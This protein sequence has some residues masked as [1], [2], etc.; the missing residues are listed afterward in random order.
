MRRRRK[1][2]S[3]LSVSL[4]P[5]LAVLICTLGVL[6]VMLVM[7]VK[8]ADDQSTA[9]QAEDDAE[10]QQR[11]E[12]LEETI[13][14]TQFQI[15]GTQSI[16]PD[17][18]ERLAQSKSNRS[19]L[20]DEIRKLKH[21][22]KSVGEQLLQLEQMKQ[23]TP[24][25]AAEFSSLEASDELAKLQESIASAQ[26]ELV[27]KRE[28]V[29]ELGATTYVIEPYK[30]GG[31]TFRR[32]IYIECTHDAI[33]LQPSGIRLE[34]RDFVPPLEP[35][36]MLDAA[37]LANRE[38]WERYDLAGNEGSPYPLIVV[39]P[40]GA[41]TFVLARLAMKSWDD[42]FGYE[43]VDDDKTLEFGKP[44]P[45]L[46]AELKQMVAIA[47]RRQRAQTEMAR[48]AKQQAARLASY[49]SRSS[50][51]PGMTVSDTY[52]G[53]VST[54]GGR[55]GEFGSGAPRGGGGSDE[56]K[57][58]ADE[59]ESARKNDDPG[60][61]SEFQNQGEFGAQ[62]LAAK[63][64]SQPT[65][66]AAAGVGANSKA[67]GGE[68]GEMAI[69]NPYQDL[70]LAKQQGANWALPSQ[71]PGATGYLR[72]IRVVCGT[73]YLE[74]RSASGES[75][76]IKMTNETAA[77][78]APLVDEIWKKIDGWG[79]SGANSFWKPQLRI[80]VLPGAETRFAE[81]KGLLYQSGLLIEE[82]RQ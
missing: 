34:K 32:P 67:A 57:T 78:V 5:F 74:L 14:L 15:H 65:Q 20:E 12:A 46:T 50:A 72:P 4:F 77:A 51:R 24:E 73:D 63:Q 13:E 75:K 66:S 56:R 31:G 70:S 40:D 30:G 71:T 26:S 48:R 55:P 68:G 80:S 82:F 53:F 69:R 23:Q 7:A 37:L 79:I 2:R 18:V 76:R 3:Q 64:S 1:K 35:G 16:R 44:D 6:I 19:Y 58:A 11:I 10:K 21:E 36:N 33:T 62:D 29:K 47:A 45:Q 25:E 42:E 39:R 22:F 9:V 49:Q 8:S 28:L 59:Y 60:K 54:D 38:Y 52:G 41:E 43:L 27:G 81:L 17:A 61:G